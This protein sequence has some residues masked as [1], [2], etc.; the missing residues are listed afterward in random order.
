M[1]FFSSPVFGS[2]LVSVVIVNSATA[3]SCQCFRRFLRGSH[4][5]RKIDGKLPNLPPCVG[6]NPAASEL[7]KS[8]NQIETPREIDRQD[9]V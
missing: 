9:R 1:F 5:F 4:L 6:K 3:H 7:R 8:S 2:H